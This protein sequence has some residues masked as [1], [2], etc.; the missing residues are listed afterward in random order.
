M[1]I[2]QKYI[3]GY[4]GLAIHFS[5]AA[6]GSDSVALLPITEASFEDSDTGLILFDNKSQAADHKD[7]L[8]TIAADLECPT[9]TNQKYIPLTLQTCCD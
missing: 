7:G 8:C 9:S 2:E 4:R 5:N 3:L 6:D 1:S